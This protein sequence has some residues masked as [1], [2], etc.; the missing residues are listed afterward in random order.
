MHYVLA[1]LM[2]FMQQGDSLRLRQQIQDLHI[3]GLTIDNIHDVGVEYCLVAVTL[4]PNIKV[5]V[6]MPK[7]GWNGR[8]LGTGN[9]GEWGKD[10][11]RQ[12]GLWGK[13]G[14]CYRQY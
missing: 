9:G 8:F 4:P 7:K 14:F 13:T 3:Q 5:Q 12:T 2:G 6:W 1:L 11:Y 10:Y